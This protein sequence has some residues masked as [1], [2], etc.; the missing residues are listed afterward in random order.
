[1][2]GVN[3]RMRRVL[4]AGADMQDRKNLG[5]RIDGHP[6]PEHLCGAAEPGSHF[7]QLEVRDVKVAEGAL[8]QGLSVRAST[9]QKGS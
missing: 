2:Q 4:R 1:L 7:I 6:Q 3:D 8:V 9:R 5:A